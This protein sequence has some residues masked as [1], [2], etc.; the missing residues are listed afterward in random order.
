MSTN[1]P[2][3]GPVFLV[4]TCDIFTHKTYCANYLESTWTRHQI[5][6][7][8]AYVWSSGSWDSLWYFSHIRH[9]CANY[10]ESAWTRHQIEYEQA[11]V[12]SSG[13]WD[14]LWYFHTQDIIVPIIWNQHGQGR[15][16]NEWM[17]SNWVQTSLCLVQWFLSLWYIRK[18]VYFSFRQ[19]S[20][21][22]PEPWHCAS[23]LWT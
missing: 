7:K 5:E 21:T 16:M 14:S 10:L 4:I 8:Q 11:Y 13:S 19:N 15:W 17:A 23:V 22:I 18:Q 6:C 20:M 3:F 1:M 12:W 9:Y 2:V